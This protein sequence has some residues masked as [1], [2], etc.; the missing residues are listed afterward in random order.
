M[1]ASSSS[2]SGWEGLDE[3]NDSSFCCDLPPDFDPSLGIPDVIN[4]IQ[5]TVAVLTALIGLP[6]TTYLLFI[7]IRHKQLHQRCFYLCL[8]ILCIEVLYYMVIP[9]TILTSTIA[10]HWVF[11]T[12]ICNMT[13]MVHD[14]F[15]F[16]MMFVIDSFTFETSIEEVD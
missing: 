5:A 15:A 14:A 6:A 7:I 2:A 16:V 11:G 9:I 3:S 12:V 8:Q 4:K 1:S 10:K 13:G